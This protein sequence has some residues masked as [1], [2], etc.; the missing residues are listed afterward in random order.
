MVTRLIFRLPFLM[1]RWP[2]PIR[3][4]IF[5]RWFCCTNKNNIKILIAPELI[6]AMVFKTLIS[7]NIFIYILYCV[8]HKSLLGFIIQKFHNVFLHE[9]FVFPDCWKIRYIVFVFR[10]Y[11]ANKCTIWSNGIFLFQNPIRI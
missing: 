9:K 11:C 2:F 3:F 6:I 8:T 7:T 4:D 5:C 10:I 1:T